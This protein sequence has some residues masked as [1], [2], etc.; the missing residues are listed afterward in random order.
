MDHRVVATL[1]SEPSIQGQDT[2]HIIIVE[3]KHGI[4]LIL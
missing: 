1:D 2:L 3:H 4:I